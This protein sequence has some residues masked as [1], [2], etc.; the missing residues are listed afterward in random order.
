MKYEK[1]A[2]K[3]IVFDENREFLVYSGNPSSQNPEQDAKNAAIAAM[4]WGKWDGVT[5]QKGADGKWI[6]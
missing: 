3:A 2:A 4:G 5:A 6:Q 1:P